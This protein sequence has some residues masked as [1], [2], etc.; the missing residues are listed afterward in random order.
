MAE[1]SLASLI[2]AEAKDVIYAKAITIAQA[3]G[4]ETETWKSGDP[5]R[6]LFDVDSR[7]HEA[8]EAG[9]V[10]AIKA[11]FLDLSSGNGTTLCARYL[12][13]TER[14]AATYATCTL[15]ITNTGSDTFTWDPDDLTAIN[16]AATGKPT[17]RNTTGGTIQPAGSVDGSG[18]PTDVLDV[19]IEAEVA[20]SD[21]SAGV[22]DIDELVTKYPNITVTNTTAAVGRDEERDA[23]L[24]ARCK[25][26]WASLS[27]NG[28]K[29]A[30]AYVATTPDLVD[31]VT[32]TRTR[33][34]PDSTVGEVLFYIADDAGAVD[35]SVVTAVEEGVE[36]YAVPHCIDVTVAS[37]ANLSQNVTYTLWVYSSINLTTA[38]IED[39][40]EDA[41][42]AALATRPIG[43]DIIP[44]A[45]TGNLYKGFLE[46]TILSAVQI[47]GVAYGFRVSI[48]TPAADVAVANNQVVTLGTV[49][50]TINLIEAP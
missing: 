21:G 1:V 18:N 3:I 34:Y 26:K 32:V 24:K 7:L 30:L 39:L 40:V 4:L 22:G 8:K 13:N 5:T 19:T 20:G 16:N 38:E 9:V 28:P 31:G 46:S 47:D 2:I 43:G 41:L 25:A 50:A 15:R 6:S 29:D 48:A 12:F 33:T 49:T 11:G 35:A 42:L 27:P 14:I 44:P 45:T 36:T 23:A 37:A 17:Y 10:E